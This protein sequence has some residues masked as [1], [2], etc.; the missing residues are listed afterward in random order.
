MGSFKVAMLLA[1]LVAVSFTMEAA[2]N[3]IATAQ[4]LGMAA[5]MSGLT[6]PVETAISHDLNVAEHKK[7]KYRG[8]GGGGGGG[9]SEE[10]R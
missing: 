1:V 5:E 7:K 10:G 3:P 2:A 8:G 4:D 6:G 9:S